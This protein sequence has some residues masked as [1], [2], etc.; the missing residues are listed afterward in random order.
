MGRKT[1]LLNFQSELLSA[2][3]LFE[4]NGSVS[5]SQLIIV[6]HLS[7]SIPCV[8]FDE[9]LQ[10]FL[11]NIFMCPEP[12]AISGDFN[13]HLDDMFNSETKK[14]MELLETLSLTQ[15]VFGHS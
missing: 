11:Q 13:F 15:H 5:S 8:F 3:S 4:T 1:S 6:S 10:L 14:F 9:F 12:L 7:L 2:W